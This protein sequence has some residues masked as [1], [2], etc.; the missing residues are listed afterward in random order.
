MVTGLR[1]TLAVLA[2]AA[3]LAAQTATQAPVEVRCPAVLGIGV[4]SDVPFCDIEVQRDPSLG[5]LVELPP[6]SGE[7]TLSFDLHNRHTYSETETRAGRAYAQYEAQIA[8]ATMA[9]EIITRGVVLT[10]FRVAGDLID[11]VSGDAGVLKAVAP[12]GV[13]RVYVTLP[14]GIE[15]VAIVGQ[16]LVV[17]RADGA[18]IFDTVGRPIAALSNA[19]LSY[20]PR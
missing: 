17:L 2:L 4:V 8:V 9:G 14:D 16:R 7:A 19:T 1:L 3:P 18:E 12:T 15:R 20:E 5:V 11:R 10:E 6:R 13:E